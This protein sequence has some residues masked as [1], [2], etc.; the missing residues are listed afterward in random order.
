ML[1]TYRSLDEAN[2][3]CLPPQMK[4][5]VCTCMESLIDAY[6]DVYDPEDDGYVVLYSPDTTDLDAVELFGRAWTDACLEGV[7]FDE[8]SGCFLTCVL[9][10][11][12][13]GYTIIVPDAEW[14]DPAFREKLL[15]ELVG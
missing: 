3:A 2:N 4:K 12:Q 15:S 14:L 6:G 1:L 8:E 13:F 9:C 11:N 7:T 10:N 5:V